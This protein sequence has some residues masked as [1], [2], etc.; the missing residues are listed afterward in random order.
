MLV[1]PAAVVEAVG[2]RIQLVTT[3]AATE[4]TATTHSQRRRQLERATESGTR[5]AVDI[6]A[7]KQLVSPSD[8]QHAVRTAV[9]RITDPATVLKKAVLAQSQR[10]ELSDSPCIGATLTRLGARY[11]DCYR[12]AVQPTA[13]SMTFIGATPERLLTR[14]GSRLKTVA[15]AGSAQ[16]GETPTADRQLRADLQSDAKTDHEHALVTAT[17][18]EQLQAHARSVD[19]GDQS[20]RQLPRVQ[21]VQ[22]PVTADIAADTP[23]FSLVDALYPTAAISGSPPATARRLVTSLEPFDRGWYTG[24]VGYCDGTGDGT[25]AVGIR[26]ALVGDR[27]ARLFAGAGIV[28]E[29][30]PTA[31]WDETQLKY[32]PMYELF[33]D[34]TEP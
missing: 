1:V 8:W 28:A 33:D 16:R 6:T 9:E 34:R 13:D 18:R 11:P 24:P 29:S 12:F 4:P 14:T 17:I 21:H 25:V 10:L 32:Q 26:S 19:I 20:I 15:L 7:T 5:P 22:T 30:E 31:E 23:F 3:S 27:Q 2:D